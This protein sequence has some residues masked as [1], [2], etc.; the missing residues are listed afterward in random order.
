MGTKVKVACSRCGGTGY[1][2]RFGV[3]FKCNGTGWEWGVKYTD[4]ERA[5]LD[6]RNERARERKAEK[7]ERER[8]QRRAIGRFRFPFAANLL[9]REP[10][11]FN[12]TFL[13][14]LAWNWQDKGWLSEKQAAAALRAAVRDIE[15][16]VEREER[17]AN[18][19]PVPE[20]RTELTGEVVK[21][22]WQD[23]DFGGAYKM[24]VEASEGFRVWGTVPRSIE[25]DVHEGD[26]VTFTA[27]VEASKD[28]PT[29]GFFKRPTKAAL[30]VTA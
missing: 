20:G 12:D 1:Y 28:D 17:M 4:E 5:Q 11:S 18:T 3:C 13:H 22:K 9:D 26:A 27:T 16:E 10:S 14:E 29:F 30:V 19:P 21:L 23:S 8:L 24:L 6:K 15:R 7:R 2:G 25:D